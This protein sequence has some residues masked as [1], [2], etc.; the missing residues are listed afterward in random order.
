MRHVH[1][2]DEVRLDDSLVNLRSLAH[3]KRVLLGV[4]GDQ[5]VR[6]GVNEVA[7]DAAQLAVEAQPVLSEFTVVE[8]LVEMSQRTYFEIFIIGVAL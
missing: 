6:S 5:R 8:V 2:V 4:L 3:G 1:G 7:L